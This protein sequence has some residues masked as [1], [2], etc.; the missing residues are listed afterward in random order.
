MV[1]SKLGPMA[2]P[3][4]VGPQVLWTGYQAACQRVVDGRWE[5]LTAFAY[6]SLFEALDWAVALDEHFAVHWRE[7][8]NDCGSA[9][10]SAFRTAS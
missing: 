1:M 10:A 5:R 6:T 9:G 8:G 7:N 4:A 2:E 3:S